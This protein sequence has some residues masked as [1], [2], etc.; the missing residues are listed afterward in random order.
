MNFFSAKKGQTIFYAVIVMG[1]IALTSIIYA[2]SISVMSV[3]SSR[4]IV[5]SK[6][7]RSLADL[8]AEYALEQIRSNSNFNGN[9]NLNFNNQQCS[10]SVISQGGES[11]EVMASGT[12]NNVVRRVKIII[13]QINPQI[14]IS[15]WQE[16]ADF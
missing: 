6:K 5:D 7:A 15:S 12:F 1:A 4:I 8:C 16:V 9:G 3:R 11:R 14:F 13:N 2:S 10:Y